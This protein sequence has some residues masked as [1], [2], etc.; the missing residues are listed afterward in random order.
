[1]RYNRVVTGFGE[2]VAGQRMD[3]NWSAR[4]KDIGHPAFTKSRILTQDREAPERMCAASGEK[5]LDSAALSGRG[6]DTH[7]QT[8]RSYICNWGERPK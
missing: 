6:S 8:N 4:N 2:A 3:D 5:G 1:V 7:A